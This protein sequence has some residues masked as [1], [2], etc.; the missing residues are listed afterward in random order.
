MHAASAPGESSES[1]LHT[2]WYAVYVTARH[3]KKVAQHLEQREVEFYLPLYRKERK[4]KDGSR[5][6]LELPLFPSYLFVRIGRADRGRV[7]GV[8]GVVSFVGGTGCEPAQLPDAEIESLR[9]GL[10]ERKA[11]PHPL[12][13]AGQRVR[14][15]SGALVGMEGFVERS[16]NRSRVVLTIDLIRKSVAVEVEASEL[17]ILEADSSFEMEA[18]V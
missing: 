12:L 4:W 7:L 13:E 11:E 15:R 16:R 2:R 3:E 10:P 1:L 18:H 9:I 17:E 8:P 5:G 6:T 14:I